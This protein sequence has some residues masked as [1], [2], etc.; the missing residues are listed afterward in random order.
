MLTNLSIKNYALIRELEIAPSPALN[1]IT[2]ETGAGKS[3]VL[4]AVGLLLGNRADTKALLSE[5]QKC[6]IE[7]EFEIEGYQLQHVFEEADLDYEEPSIIRREINPNGKSRAFINDVPTTLDVLKKIGLRL[8]D[9]HSQNESIEIAKKE[10]RLN[11]LDDYAQ[12]SG[13]RE[14]YHRAYLDFK[15]SEKALDNLKNK[16]EK[17]NRE[18]DYNSFLLDELA[19]AALKA[20]EQEELES[21]LKILDNS[22]DIKLKL[23]QIVGE[24]QDNDFAVSDRLM[25]MNNLLRSTASFSSELEGL[26]ERFTSSVTEL[27]DI[28]NALGDV[29]ESVEHDPQRIDEVNQRLGLIYQLQQKHQVLDVEGLLEIQGTLE[30]KALAS[31]N[32]DEE[33]KKQQRL[34]EES[35]KQ[36][37]S[38]ADKLSAKRIAMLGKFSDDVNQLLG[39]VGMPDGRLQLS[40]KPI[41]PSTSGKD[42]IEMLFSANKGISPQPVAKVAS[43]GEFSRL[44]LCIKYLLATKTAMPTIIFDEIDTGVSGEI[45]KKMALMMKKMSQRHQVIAISHLPQIAAKGDTHYF[46]YKNNNSETTESFIKKLDN[47]GHVLEI[48]KMLGGENPTEAA[49]KNAREL[50]EK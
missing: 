13:L 1:I 16:Q 39:Y 4:G 21:E 18:E 31:Q 24:F 22:E 41:E 7:G 9:I 33:I 42:E 17:L 3:I 37:L 45:A 6:V 29:L 43:G 2:G 40:H 46:V 28:V 34:F 27:K 35:Q 25:E 38:L 14:T 50:I 12:V 20:G 19:K 47:N 23:A 5:D 49:L 32:L 48:A 26:N 36:L 8:L 15:K 44:M 11:I 10:A 30:E